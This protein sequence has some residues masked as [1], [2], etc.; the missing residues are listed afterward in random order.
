LPSLFQQ[1]VSAE[2]GKCRPT[3][4]P[5]C[6]LPT[7]PSTDA[8]RAETP[9]FQSAIF[10]RPAASAGVASTPPVDFAAFLE[11]LQSFSG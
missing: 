6:I 10:I 1:E 4:D 7:S 5:P 3:F 8:G 11:S 2:R 9:G